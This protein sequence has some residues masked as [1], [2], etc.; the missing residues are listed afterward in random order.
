MTGDVDNGQTDFPDDNF[1]NGGTSNASDNNS[2]V[3]S[4]TSN[5]S[6]SSGSTGDGEN[7]F[8]AQ[9]TIGGDE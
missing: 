1:N 9:E 8:N 7:I 2:N 4:N 3:S 6:S 5:N